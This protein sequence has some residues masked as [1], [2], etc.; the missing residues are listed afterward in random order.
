MV[1]KYNRFTK[2][3]NKFIRNNYLKLGN[4]QIRGILGRKN[5][6]V[7]NRLIKLKLKRPKELV[8]NLIKKTNFKKGHIHSEEILKKISESKKGKG[9]RI[10]NKLSLKIMKRIPKELLYKKYVLEKKSLPIISKEVGLNL[11]TIHNYLHFYKIPV[12]S[13]IEAKAISNNSIGKNNPFYGK[14]HTKEM[15]KMQ[16][17]KRAKQIFPL[18]DTKIEVK[19]QDFLKQLGIDFFTH[20]YMKEIEHSYQC[21]I[22]IPKLNLVIECDGDYWHKFPIGREIDTVRTSELISKGFKV[23][24]LWEHEIKVMDINDFENKINSFGGIR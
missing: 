23:L 12:R 14:N 22:L 19:I 4:K 7:S 24:R 9:T 10:D 17:E 16:R 2:E 21:D 1:N 3:E 8:S 5:T 20:Q 13:G 6:A 18:K 11:S 15:K